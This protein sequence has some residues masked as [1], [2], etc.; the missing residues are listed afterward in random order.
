MT[1]LRVG[2]TV[3]VY[4][5]D[6]DTPSKFEPIGIILEISYGLLKIQINNDQYPFA[7]ERGDIIWYHQK[8]CELV[9]IEGEIEVGDEVLYDERRWIVIKKTPHKDYYYFELQNEHDDY[10]KGAFYDLQLIKKAEKK[11]DKNNEDKKIIKPKP[12]LG[13]EAY[14][15]KIY[16]LEDK[17]EILEDHIKQMEIFL[18]KLEHNINYCHNIMDEVNKIKNDILSLRRKLE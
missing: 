6:E 11:T 7:V 14:I 18:W 16:E 12:P 9:T 8:Q 5:C 2:D 13:L 17:I 10:V 4:T 15:K 1:E 3:K